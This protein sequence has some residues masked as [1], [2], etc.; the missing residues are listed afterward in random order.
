MIQNPSDPDATYW[1]QAE[2]EYQGYVANLEET[3]GKNGSVITD[4]QYEQNN[5]SD[6]QF[7][8]DSLARTEVQDETTTVVAD[9]A[10]SGKENHDLAAEKNIQL[11]N[12]DL[13]GKTID[14]SLQ[15]LYLMKKVQKSCVVLPDMNQ[16]AAV[17]LEKNSNSSIFSAQKISCWQ[18]AGTGTDMWKIFLRM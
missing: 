8:K 3:V 4:Y 2:K 1:V 12:T 6:S 16:K 14:S 15:S 5:Y 7:L 13:S 9:G 10:Y 17:M 18:N 11:V